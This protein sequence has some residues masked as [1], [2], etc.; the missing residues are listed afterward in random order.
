MLI[1]IAMC[2]ANGYVMYAYCYCYADCYVNGSV[3]VMLISIL[4]MALLLLLS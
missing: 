1:V 2:S 3:Y 4:C